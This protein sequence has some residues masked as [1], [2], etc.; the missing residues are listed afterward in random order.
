MTPRVRQY[1]SEAARE[2]GTTSAAVF[3]RDRPPAT[4]GARHAAMRR[5]RADGFALTQI[6]RWF[7]RH[8]T[9]VLNATRSVATDRDLQVSDYGRATATEGKA[10]SEGGDALPASRNVAAAPGYSPA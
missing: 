10:F 1:V 9:S 4:I 5:L 6:G 2:H 7:G 8:H 3:G